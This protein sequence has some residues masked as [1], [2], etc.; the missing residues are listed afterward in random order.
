MSRRLSQVL[1]EARRAGIVIQESDAGTQALR[2]AYG[3]VMSLEQRRD[4]LARAW[5]SS[6]ASLSQAPLLFVAI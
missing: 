5:A 3:R 2:L 6:Y 4:R 1:A